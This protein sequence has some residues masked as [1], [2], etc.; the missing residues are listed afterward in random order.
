MQRGVS[1]PSGG[2]GLIS[3]LALSLAAA[4]CSSTGPGMS[5]LA[6]QAA[7][8]YDA[9]I[10]FESIDGAPVAIAHRMVGDLGEEAALR[11]IAVAPAGSAATYRL[12]GYLSAH[13]E[14]GSVAVI[15]AW[16]V[17]DSGLQRAFRL[18]GEER[19]NAGG[20]ISGNAWAAV[21]ET[22]LRR[23]AR[24]GMQQLAGFIA[25]GPPPAAPEPPSTPQPGGDP[26]VAALDVSEPPTAAADAAVPPL[27]HRRPAAPGMVATA[28]L[29]G[30]PP[31]R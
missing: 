4:G 23:M 29:S 17:Y 8:G 12:R 20:R 25:S 2:V 31:A 5:G 18:S 24:S 16:D 10:A 9:G 7:A 15:W 11:R 22:V 21:D 27:P 30:D 26:A 28:A 3:S 19:A 14:R 13:P 6:P 1:R